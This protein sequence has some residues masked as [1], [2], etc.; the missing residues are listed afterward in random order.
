MDDY[1]YM[2]IFSPII[3]CCRCKILVEVDSYIAIMETVYRATSYGFYPWGLCSRHQ[4][5]NLN[6]GS[7][8]G[9]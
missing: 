6:I 3:W 5:P 4:C 1:R 9:K 7:E 8:S 2:A